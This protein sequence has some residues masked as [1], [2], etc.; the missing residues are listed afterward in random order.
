L[1]ALHAGVAHAA[2]TPAADRQAPGR[3][4]PHVTLAHRMPRVQ[5]TAALEVLPDDDVPV[6]L[7]RARRWDS[8]ERRAWMVEADPGGHERPGRR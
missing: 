7:D 8:T 5:L 4:V 3:W 6:L 2:R 1:L